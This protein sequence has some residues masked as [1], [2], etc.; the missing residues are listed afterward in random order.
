M[1]ES[2]QASLVETSTAMMTMGKGRGIKKGRKKGH[3]TKNIS[4]TR[5]S[6][7]T[8]ALEHNPGSSM[9]KPTQKPSTD[10]GVSDSTSRMT[11]TQLQ[12]IYTASLKLHK[13][14]WIV[15]LKDQQQNQQICI[16][17]LRDQ[18]KIFLVRLKQ[19][20]PQQQICLVRLKQHLPQQQIC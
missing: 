14:R 12:P 9:T 17:R 18:Q 4:Q 16:V 15:R 13:H 19:H 5:D 6:P 8:S 3:H 7:S 10:T 20:L 2:N 1:S 11:D